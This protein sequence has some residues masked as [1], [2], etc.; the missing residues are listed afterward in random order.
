MNYLAE[1]QEDFQS[2]DGWPQPVSK[3]K[4]YVALVTNPRG[5]R[6]CHICTTA[7]TTEEGFTCFECLDKLAD[8][9][10][11]KQVLFGKEEFEDQRELK[12][13]VMDVLHGL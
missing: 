4:R 1:N 12:D 10:K 11:C 6:K 2:A 9:A 13:I 5:N 7:I 3:T 8:K